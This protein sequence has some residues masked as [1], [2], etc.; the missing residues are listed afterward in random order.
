MTDDVLGQAAGLDDDQIV[1]KA[2]GLPIDNLAVVRVFPGGKDNPETVVVTVRDKAGEVVWALSGT[3]GVPV[4]ANEAEGSG[5]GVSQSAA[6]AVSETVE[7][8]TEASEEAR[9]RY[10][11]EFIWFQDMVGVNQHGSVVSSWS[12]AYQGKYKKHLDAAEFYRAV[13]RAD[14]AEEYEANSDKV[15]A[16]AALGTVGALGMAGGGLWWV[17]A[18]TGP[19]TEGGVP[20]G[21]PAALTLVSGVAMIGGFSS[22]PE[23]VHPIPP[24]EARELA[25]K[26]NKKLKEEL[27]LSKDYSPMPRASR[28]SIKYNFGLGA[29]PGGAAGVLRVE[30]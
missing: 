12:S 5:R 11:K 4:E 26:H 9:E 8:E 19:D 28:N 13:G 18:A 27:G 30:F 6:E 10:A 20:S 29:A 23:K 24:S 22:I 16:G 15:V 3:S 1:A 7:A 2:Q 25:D 17:V 21:V 14:L